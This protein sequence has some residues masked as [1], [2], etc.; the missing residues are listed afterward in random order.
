MNNPSPTSSPFYTLSDMVD[1]EFYHYFVQ[2]FLHLEGFT[3]KA[4][5]IL[6]GKEH[7][8]NRLMELRNDP[9]YDVGNFKTKMSEIIGN[10]QNLPKYS[11][12]DIMN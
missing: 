9:I 2:K 6:L 3:R 11:L 8:F 4:D 1:V 10:V 12:V 7:V 5:H